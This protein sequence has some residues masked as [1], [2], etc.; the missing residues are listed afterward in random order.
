MAEDDSY[1]ESA[2]L[3]E[4]DVVV[5]DF[6]FLPMDATPVRCGYLQ[7]RLFSPTGN[8][9]LITVLCCDP[10]GVESDMLILPVGTRRYSLSYLFHKAD[11]D[12]GWTDSDLE[13]E[14]PLA[15][16][17]SVVEIAGNLDWKNLSFDESS[18]RRRF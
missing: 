10:S 9:R 8:K 7:Y 3:F 15:S 11:M 14:V 12:A 5:I 6:D 4:Q 18:Q 2:G 13:G 1:S 16:I 17:S